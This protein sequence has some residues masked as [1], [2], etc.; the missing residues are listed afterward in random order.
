MILLRE[1]LLAT[2]AE[3]LAG[4]REGQFSGFGYDSRITRAGELFVAMVTETGDGHDYIEQACAHGARGV[5]CQ[6]PPT[7]YLPGVSYLRVDDT[8]VALGAYARYIL[9]QRDMTVIAVAGSVGKTS[10]KRAIT[11]ILGDNEPV[12]AS[13]ENYSGRFGL[14]IS[15]GEL[16]PTQRTALLELACDNLGE[17]AALVRMTQPKLAVITRLGPT[18]L[19]VFGSEAVFADEHAH[20]IR[21]LP[22]DGCAILNADDPIVARLVDVSP[23]RVIR[24][25]LAA[26]ADLRADG[27]RT[28]A[29]GIDMTLHWQ[30]KSHP[31]H[32]P[33]LGAHHAY[34]AL[35]ARRHRAGPRRRLGSDR[36]GTG[37]ADPAGRPHVSPR[38]P[39][40]LTIARRQL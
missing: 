27:V 32:L 36:C 37:V 1:L 17:M 38:G 21:S 4:P 15:L 23:C 28:D 31:V 19:D 3:L 26:G 25:G 16:E 11:A 14:P 24:Y 29:V 39:Q 2:G 33:L 6:Q 30:G 18:H 7:H 8:L 13:R 20:L 40:R 9:R 12:F 34:T 22:S 10:T 5:L 35:A